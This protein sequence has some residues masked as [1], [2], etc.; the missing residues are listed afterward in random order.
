[1]IPERPGG[2]L[3]VA[4]AAARAQVLGTLNEIELRA[5]GYLI[6]KWLL[7]LLV[8]EFLLLALYAWTT[9]PGS[10]TVAASIASTQQAPPTPQDAW[11]TSIKDLGQIFLLTPIFPLIGAVIG[12]MFG[13]QQQTSP[14]A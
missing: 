3:N 1:M 8:F 6:F 11:V 5:Y 9:F 12:Y 10:V 13:R 2:T 7:A 14:P 4:D